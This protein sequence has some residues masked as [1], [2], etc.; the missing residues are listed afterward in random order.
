MT[1]ELDLPPTG[2]FNREDYRKHNHRWG[3]RGP[4]YPQTPYVTIGPLPDDM[5]DRI[6]EEAKKRSVTRARLVHNVMAAIF[7]DDLFA[8]VLED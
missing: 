2:P 4:G 6:D 8:A 3:P 5:V 1:K 7:E